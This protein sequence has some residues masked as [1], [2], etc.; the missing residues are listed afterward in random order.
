MIWSAKN[1]SLSAQAC[2]LLLV[3]GFLSTTSF[4]SGAA[5]IRQ[6][7]GAR[8]GLSALSSSPIRQVTSATLLRPKPRLELL[9]SS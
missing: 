3:A 4:I 1:K 7:G 6:A 8:E 2:G 9:M 5:R